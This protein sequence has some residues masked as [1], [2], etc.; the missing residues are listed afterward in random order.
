ME[1]LKNENKSESIYAF[2]YKERTPFA[3]AKLCGSEKTSSI[4]GSV[5]FFTTPLGVLVHAELCGLPKRRKTGVYNFCVRSGE[6]TE[7][8]RASVGD[9]R[10]FCAVMPVA[11]EKDGCADCSVVTRK[12]VP[13]DL[14]GKRIAV[15][16]RRLGCPK[17]ESS[18]VA[19]GNIAYL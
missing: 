10:S 9:K 8:I 5:E 6:Q 3:R 17:D 2:L 18:A 11:Y 7:C 4:R 14:V 19:V 1:T 15:Y 12:I 13:S 16:E